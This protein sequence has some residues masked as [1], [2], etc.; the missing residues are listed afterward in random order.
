MCFE[1]AGQPARCGRLT[2]S[3]LCRLDLRPGVAT[4]A[5]GQV[6]TPTTLLNGCLLESVC[7]NKTLDGLHIKRIFLCCLAWAVGGLLDV[8]RRPA[9]DSELRTLSHTASNKASC[10]AH[11]TGSHELP[12]GTPIMHK[13][14]GGGPHCGLLHT[15]SR[16]S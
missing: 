16:S 11:A 7:A 10:S 13:L 4:E 3:M 9:F 1:E 15:C 14:S 5:V 12:A 6:G 2:V 8:E